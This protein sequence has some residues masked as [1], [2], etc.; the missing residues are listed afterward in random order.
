MPWHLLYTAFAALSLPLLLAP[1]SAAAPN[2]EGRLRRLWTVGGALY[3]AWPLS[4]ALLLRD[5]PQGRE[6]VFMLLVVAFAVD[7]G[8]YAVGRAFGRHMLAPRISPNKTR[9]GAVG[10]V[11][12]GIIASV[13]MVSLFQLPVGLVEAG[14]WGILLAIVAQIG[15]LYE[16]ALKRRLEAKDAGSLI[17]GHGGLL[18]RLDSI[19]AVSLMLYYLVQWRTTPVA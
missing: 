2:G 4:A 6:W 1:A 17:P 5:E 14:V 9:E 7:T 3:L 15:D 19:L 12:A 8:A 18:D 11:I 13:A 10:G 16:S